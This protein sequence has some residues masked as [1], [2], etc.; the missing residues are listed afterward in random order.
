MYTVHLQKDRD[1]MFDGILLVN[2]SLSGVMGAT[3]GQ[4][5]IV[6]LE[7]VVFQPNEWHKNLTVVIL[8]DN[9]TEGGEVFTL[10]VTAIPANAIQYKYY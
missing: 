1:A 7:V 10:S 5:F 9:I 8:P 3:E 2:V 4:D 6:V